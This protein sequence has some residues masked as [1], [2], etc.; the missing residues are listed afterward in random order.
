MNIY[1]CVSQVPDTET[2]IKIAADGKSIEETDVNYILNPFDE[3]AVEEGLRLKEAHGGEVTVISVGNDLIINTIRKAL[4]MGADKA[5][6]IKTSDKLD[7]FSAAEAVANYLKD[8]KADII[9][10]GK[11]SVDTNSSQFATFLAALLDY[12]VINVCVKLEVSGTILKAERE[13][14]GGKE[15]IEASLPAV[16]SCQ[17]GI[18]EPRLPTLKGIMASKTKKPEE[19]ALSVSNLTLEVIGMTKPP[20]KAAG[21]IVG[22]DASAVPALLDLLQNEAKVI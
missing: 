10:T 7:G 5:V 13:I 18:N 4:A 19:V 14:E 11:E 12:A 8:K 21:R 15:I 9:L 3:N 17:N 22:T 20:A 2:R 16:V 6:H 1:V